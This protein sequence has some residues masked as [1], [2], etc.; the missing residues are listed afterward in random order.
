VNKGGGGGGVGRRHWGAPAGTVR[1][2]RRLAKSSFASPSPR[3]SLRGM[4]LCARN[5]KKNQA[6][7][8][9]SQ[10]QNAALCARSA[11][12]LLSL[13]I[14]FTEPQGFVMMQRILQRWG[15]LAWCVP[16]AHLCPSAA[17]SRFCPS[18]IVLSNYS[19]SI[20][21]KFQFNPG[22]RQFLNDR[23]PARWGV[24][25]SYGRFLPS[26]NSS[27]GLG[28]TRA[29]A[30]LRGKNISYMPSSASSF[31]SNSFPWS[32]NWCWS[33]SNP[34]ATRSG[35]MRSSPARKLPRP[36]NPGSV[37]ARLGGQHYLT[38]LACP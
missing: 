18:I 11:E 1:P 4:H 15:Y 3:T 22:Y 29:G 38:A 14:F 2:V 10:V 8:S 5:P 26:N 13:Q 21:P 35:G 23:V 16:P 19:C 6:P 28:Y 32:V 9:T 31:I 30:H 27:G 25:N 37:C 17:P 34:D 24:L 12:G 20:F 36:Q 33:G 7:R